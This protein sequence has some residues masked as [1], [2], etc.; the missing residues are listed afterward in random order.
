MR[1]ANRILFDKLSIRWRTDL[2]I[3]QA[4]KGIMNYE[5]WAMR[6]SPPQDE[7]YAAA[8]EIVKGL[9]PEEFA[10]FE[11]DPFG[12]VAPQRTEKE[13]L[14]NQALE[15]RAQINRAVEEEEYE[16]AEVLQRTLDVIELKYN[17][18]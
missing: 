3:A 18:L 8:E 6:Q 10:K 12:N 9:S 5:E 4:F 15:I 2:G 13:K 17:K 7:Y 1:K 11:S 14:Y 16:V